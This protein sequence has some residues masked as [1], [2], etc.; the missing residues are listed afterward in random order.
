MSVP[1]ITIYDTATRKKQPLLEPGAAELSFYSCGPTVYQRI[2]IGNARSFV[3]PMA[4]VRYLRF[5]GLPVRYVSNITDINDKI[6][7][8]AAEQGMSSGQLARQ[9]T[10]WYIADTN[11]LGLGRPDEEPRASDWVRQMIELIE[12]LITAGAAYESAGDVYFRVDSY[13]QYGK[14]SNRQLE[15]MIQGSRDDLEGGAKEHSHDFAL[16]KATKPGEDTSWDSPWGAGRPG[17]HI[18]CS[19]MGE[20][21]LGRAFDVHGGGI[22]LMFPHHENEVAQSRA[23]GRP[24]ARLWMHYGMLEI[25]GG[26]MSK[27]EGN[28]TT[29]REVLDLWP[30]T[31]LLLLFYSAS[32]RNPLAFSDA[33]LEEAQASGQRITESLRRSERYLGSVETRNAGDPNFVDS[34]RYWEGLHEALQDDFNMP[35]AMSELFGLVHDLNTAVNEHATPQ[36]VRDLRAAILEFCEVFGLSA[37]APQPVN[38]TDEVRELLAEREAARARKDFEASDRIRDTLAEMGYVVRDTKDGADV[39]QGDEA[40]AGGEAVVDASNAESVE[41]AGVGEHD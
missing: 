3:T 10:E 1:K 36:I 15:E 8:A 24:F 30:A 29:L 4:F 33:A 37:L 7:A 31:T 20:H 11:E 32:Y 2:H 17:W 28:I 9:A 27:S 21:L 14:L 35:M 40:S 18:E 26:K 25:G 16:W 19:A 6:Y 41:A 39:V 12:E 23:A 34:S 5:C 38:L 13:K 22:D